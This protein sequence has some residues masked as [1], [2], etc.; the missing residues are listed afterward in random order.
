MKITSHNLLNGK[1][2][3][4]KFFKKNI[5]S[6]IDFRTFIT[7]SNTSDFMDT[8]RFIQS[9]ELQD[10]IAA[11]PAPRVTRG[12]FN[13]AMDLAN[14]EQSFVADK[15]I[16]SFVAGVSPQYQKDVLNC[17]LLAQMA[18]NKK[19][20]NGS[21]D[22]L[23]WYQEYIDVLSKLGWVVE[24][25]DVNTYEAKGSIVKVENVVIDILVSAFGNSYLNI[26]T[27]TLNALKTSKES[28]KLIA[29]E[30][31]TNDV[32]KGCFQLATAVEENSSIMMEVGTFL[33]SSSNKIKQIL[34]FEFER[35]KTKLEYINRRATLNVDIFS[36]YRNDVA[37]KLDDKVGKYISEIDI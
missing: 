3:G 35:D 1:E 23:K 19:Y 8:K 4:F 20:K 22:T 15:T 5:K 7:S 16:V 14:S 33:L 30:T 36:K 26:I 37:A 29:F 9:L 13:K 17:T 34:F 25:A 28:K 27:K 11:Y 10:P 18:A 12:K 6:Q 21:G 24:S 2:L 31:N 32:Q